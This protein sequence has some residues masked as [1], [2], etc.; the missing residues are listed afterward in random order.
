MFDPAASD[1][2]RGA[3]AEQTLAQES[4]TPGHGRRVVVTGAS[5][6]VGTHTCRV[7]ASE[8]WRVLALVRNAAK[9]AERLAHMPI[10][11]RVGDILDA[12]YLR[13]SMDGA[14]AVVHLAAVAIESHGDTYQ[15]ANVEATR[16][17]IAAACASRVSR[18]IHMSQNGS[19]SASP[20]R[21]LQSKGVAQDLV[22]SSPLK[23]TVLRPSV[24]FGPED[25]FANVLA[26]LARVTPLVLPLPA[27][28]AT[29]FQPVAVDDVAAV[30][31]RALADDNTISRM[32][33][34]GGPIELTL[35][36]IAERILVAMNARRHVVGVPTA[37]VRPLVAAMWHLL[38]RPPVTT[39]LLETLAQDNIVPDNALAT[40]FGISPAPFAPEELLYLKR[41]TFG[42]ALK[43]FFG[44]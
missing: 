44:N 2:G 19:D 11:I 41:I 22:T 13:S 12:P 14:A 4:D 18:I 36:Q 6:F 34:L 23:W 5:G 42:D 39:E 1:T 37:A 35:R 17:V 30:V 25:A 7:L 28:G 27:Y 9:A 20:H 26:R 33:A 16:A 43:S 24:I 3:V 8:G 21:F 40:V 10:E 15:S 32:F 38:P 29:R 31:A